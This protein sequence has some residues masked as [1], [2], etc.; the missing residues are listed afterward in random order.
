MRVNRSVDPDQHYTLPLFTH[1]EPMVPELFLTEESVK[2]QRT[3]PVL[4]GPDGAMQNLTGFFLNALWKFCVK[5]LR[6]SSPK[7]LEDWSVRKEKLRAFLFTL[8]Y[9]H[10]HINILSLETKIAVISVTVPPRPHTHIHTLHIQDDL[11]R[12][13]CRRMAALDHPSTHP[14]P[15]TLIQQ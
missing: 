4:T 13:W 11:V 1:P 10:T 15:R 7:R 12:M 6:G 5:N 8:C 2:V 14:L 3:Q 9:T